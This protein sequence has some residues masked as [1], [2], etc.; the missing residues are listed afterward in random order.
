[1]PNDRDFGI[2]TMATT[3]DAI[4]RSCALAASVRRHHPEWPTT[5]LTTQPTAAVPGGF[6]TSIVHIETPEP[7]GG[8]MRFM[9][10]LVHPFTLSPYERTLFLDDDTLVIRPIDRIIRDHFAGR[11]LAINCQR[12]PQDGNRL[13][14]NHLDPAV[15]CGEL[16]TDSCWN[17]YGGGHMYFERSAGTPPAL[18]A[19]AVDVVLHER[20]LYER[21]S[22][23]TI[24]S[25]ELA[26]LIAANRGGVDMP[27]APD[28][29]DALSLRLA[30][31][32]RFSVTTSC[33]RWPDR[34]WGQS[35]DDVAVLHFCSSSKLAANYAREIHRLTGLRQCADR[36]AKGVLRRC[37]HDLRQF[38]IRG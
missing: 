25:D 17:T 1:M 22:G 14:T 10:K 26:L 36:G 21:W 12:S 19:A 13:G 5:L 29:V 30:E 2:V 4:V 38:F 3:A 33:Y 31:S 15:V 35:I 7:F 27:T 9:N 37:R 24:V 28:F 8:D 6:F 32:V 18:A 34:S 11:A 16:G 23:Q 20:E